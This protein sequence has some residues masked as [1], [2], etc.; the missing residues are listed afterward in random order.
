[1]ELLFAVPRQ[2]GVSPVVEA[3]ETLWC[4]RETVCG[5]FRE[6]SLQPRSLP[7]STQINLIF[8]L[9]NLSHCPGNLIKYSC[10]FLPLSLVYLAELLSFYHSR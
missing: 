1:M 6:V 9:T 7:A 5:A 8:R 2:E 10:S 3:W 4:G